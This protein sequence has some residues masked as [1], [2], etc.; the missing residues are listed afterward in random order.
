MVSFKHVKLPYKNQ[1]IYKIQI[2]LLFMIKGKLVMHLFTRK[3]EN[4]KSFI[5]I[6]Y[7]ACLNKQ[8]PKNIKNISVP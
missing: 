8:L 2:I 7:N 1:F 3:Q 6:H 5:K 4:N